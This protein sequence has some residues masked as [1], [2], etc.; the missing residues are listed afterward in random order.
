MI[1]LI[2]QSLEYLNRKSTDKAEWDSL[3]IVVLNE[4]VEVD[5]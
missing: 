3:E 2:L 4:L 1:L 5:T